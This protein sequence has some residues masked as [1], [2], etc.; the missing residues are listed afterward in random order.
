MNWLA[1]F[2]FARSLGAGIRGYSRYSD[3]L[4]RLHLVRPG[5]DEPLSLE[6]TENWSSK[7]IQ[8]SQ[9]FWNRQYLTFNDPELSQI[10]HSMRANQTTAILL[11]AAAFL[12][13]VS[14]FFLNGA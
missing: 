11:L 6:P 5:K 14:T 4:A 3:F 12:A 8:I 7:N 1:L 10:G 13:K 9:F 2:L